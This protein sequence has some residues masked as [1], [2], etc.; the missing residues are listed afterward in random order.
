MDQIELCSDVT[1]PFTSF[2]VDRCW[3]TPLTPVQIG[4]ADTRNT[5]GRIS[6][7]KLAD[8]KHLQIG[9]N[10]LALMDKL[11]QDD[12]LTRLENCLL[13]KVAYVSNK[14]AK[15]KAK[16]LNIKCLICANQ[17]MEKQDIT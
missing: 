10:V 1:R 9:L 8:G 3:L 17:H 12:T 5:S 2:S 6:F 11:A 16:L 14:L 15:A 7:P 4:T 13:S